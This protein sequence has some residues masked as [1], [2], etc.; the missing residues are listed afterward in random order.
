MK[1]LTKTK[2][3]IHGIAGMKLNETN[4]IPKYINKK[5]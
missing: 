2:I 5:N 4:F 1:F 3:I